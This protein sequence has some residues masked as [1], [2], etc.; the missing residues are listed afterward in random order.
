MGEREE[1]SPYLL[2]SEFVM[3]LLKE[4]LTPHA[5]CVYL[6]L[7]AKGGEQT[8]PAKDGIGR[9]GV[10]VC[11]MCVSARALFRF[12]SRGYYQEAD[13]RDSRNPD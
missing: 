5:Y 10:L 1:D 9:K 6:W 7:Q 11:V 2:F 3:T 12:D 13:W 8:S 4:K